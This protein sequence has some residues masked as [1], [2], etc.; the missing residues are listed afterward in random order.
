[1]IRWDDATGNN[2]N[3]HQ[4]YEYEDLLQ[5]K[6]WE[7]N[8]TN[9]PEK[10]KQKQKTIL[11]KQQFGYPGDWAKHTETG[12]ELVFGSQNAKEYKREV[13]MKISHW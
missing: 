11:E 5:I 9:F 1:M 10:K 7:L 8:R 6:R 13:C 4:N 2:G 3:I 12:R